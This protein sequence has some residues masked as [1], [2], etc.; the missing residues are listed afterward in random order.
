MKTKLMNILKFGAY[1]ANK[2][3]DGPGKKI[4]QKLKSCTGSIEHTTASAKKNRSRVLGMA[5]HF[6]LSS[7]MFTVSPDDRMNLQIRLYTGP[8]ENISLP[9]LKHKKKS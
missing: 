9:S 4:I 2:N 3:R 7:V 1:L 8:G 6:G 5:T